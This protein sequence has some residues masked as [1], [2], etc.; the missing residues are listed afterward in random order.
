MSLLVGTIVTVVWVIRNLI[1]CC[2]RMVYYSQ[3]WSGGVPEAVGA[4]FIGPELGEPPETNELRR[5]K[6]GSD[7]E[8]WVMVRRNGATAIF[9]VQ[10]ST[11]IKSAGLH[12]TVEPGTLRGDAELVG[13]LHGH[14]RVH[15]CRHDSCSEDGPHFKQYA[16]VKPFNPEVFQ[17]SAATSGAQEAGTQFVGWFRRGAATAVRKAKDFASESETEVIPCMAHRIRWEDSQGGHVLSDAGCKA[18]GS[19]LQLLEEDVPPS[20]GVCTLCPTHAS[21]YLMTRFQLKCAIA[22]CFRVGQKG[23]GGLLLCA[24]HEETT[25]SNPRRSSRSR[26]RT[27]EKAEE[28]GE[29]ERDEGPRRRVRQEKEA[30]E[31]SGAEQLLDE[32]R[33]AVEVTP[34][35]RTRKRTA[36]DGSPGRTPRSA[37][38][39]SLAKLGMVNSPDRREMISTLEEFMAQFVD[40]KELGVD[41]EDIRNQMAAASGMTVVDFTQVLYDQALEEQRKGT[42]GLTKFLAKWRKQIAAG[43]VMRGDKPS[44]PGSWSLV[45]SPHDAKASSASQPPRTPEATTPAGR[46]GGL[47]VLGPPGI[48]NSADRKA[49]TGGPEGDVHMADLAK[50]IQHQTAELASLVKSQHETGATTSSGTIKSLGRTSEELVYLLRACGQYT[51]E[52][53]EN[54]YGAN[55]ANALLAAQAGA[56]TRLRSAGFRQKVT[57]RLAVGIAGPYWGTQEKFALSVADFVPC[58]DAELDQHAVETRTGKPQNE[59]RPPAPARYEDWANRV[60]RQTDIWC[61]VYGKEWR[62]VREHAAQVLGEWHLGAPHWWPLQILC[63][64]WEELHWRFVEELKAE[65]RKIKGMSGRETM[66]LSDLR[67]LRVDARRDRTAPPAASSNL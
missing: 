40:G 45:G 1:R 33:K 17:L 44:P 51:V 22:D 60:K 54:E 12:L 61:L 62:A 52:V 8:R 49:G 4:R 67:F 11:S 46:G 63:E 37:V 53:G 18:V 30:V 42:K 58:S 56:S 28:F 39:R 48:Y 20:V 10:D 57:T 32:V 27:R 19:E 15:L 38:Q 7:G 43:R 41:E 9:K 23:G 16:T 5:L 47:A 26:S 64:V 34:P 24:A 66:S 36:D 59:Q 50:A 29:F 25:R 14:D 35:L 6:K 3:R 2:G 13:S 31:D 21:K 55:L 65:L